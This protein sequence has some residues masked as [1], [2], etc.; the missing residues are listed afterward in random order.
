MLTGPLASVRFAIM[1]PCE[2]DRYDSGRMIIELVEINPGCR[3]SFRQA[4]S[5]ILQALAG[6]Y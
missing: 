2:P 4:V 5:A 6:A 1:I 3:L